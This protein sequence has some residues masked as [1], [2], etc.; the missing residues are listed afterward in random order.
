[1][2]RELIVLELPRA[3]F[4]VLRDL[5]PNVRPSIGR[6]SRFDYDER[7]VLVE[8]ISEDD[9]SVVQVDTGLSL[10]EQL[11][12]VASKVQDEIQSDSTV[13]GSTWPRCP[14]HPD[15]HPLQPV[16]SA[17]YAWWFCPLN[18]QAI[19]KIGRLGEVKS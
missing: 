1:M 9:V 19:W 6:V 11:V 7:S 12:A 13:L 4:M 3:I 10:T 8:L 18:R 14:V 15:T 17:D 5:P 16:C 2:A